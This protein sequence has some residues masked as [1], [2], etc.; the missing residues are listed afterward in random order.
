MLGANLNQSVKLFNLDEM[1]Y[2]F[3][4]HGFYVIKKKVNKNKYKILKTLI[5]CRTSNF[6]FQTPKEIISLLKNN[7][8]II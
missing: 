8:L 6:N 2:I 7:N 4:E 1:N 3:D 5:S